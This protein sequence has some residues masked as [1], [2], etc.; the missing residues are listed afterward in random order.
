MKKLSILF[1]L[2]TFTLQ[3]MAA[4]PNTF[5]AGTPAKASKVNENFDYLDAKI[6]DSCN[7]SDTLPNTYTYTATDLAS[8][9]VLN[10]STAGEAIQYKMLTFPIYD[11]STGKRYAV[12]IPYNANVGIS[13]YNTNVG[14]G[15][16]E[17]ISGFPA[18]IGGDE[19][20]GIQRADNGSYSLTKSFSSQNVSIKIGSTRISL[21]LWFFE[22]SGFTNG[23]DNGTPFDLTDDITSGVQSIRMTAAIAE[24]D[25]YI[26][27]IIITEI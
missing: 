10:L 21:G 11:H 3:A 4:V 25:A 26:D 6:D 22:N 8:G 16:S 1:A 24:I 17:V 19:V 9:S 20:Q 2:T 15:G 14:C 13:I 7:K 27:Y 23:T 18:Y 5:V 12:K